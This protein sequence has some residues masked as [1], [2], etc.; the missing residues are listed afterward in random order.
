MG[1]M[2]INPKKYGGLLAKRLPKLIETGEELERFSGMLESLDRLGR[3]L[4]PEEKALESLLLRL[5]QDYDQK[6]E[7]PDA[8]P[9]RV[10]QYL[11]EQ[12][13]LR[14]ADLLPIFGARS[15]ASD[16]VSG[17]REPSKAHI[18]K[19]ADFFHVSPE[20]FL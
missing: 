17:K 13:G 4:T 7:L 12:R 11:M 1:L 6:I 10:I 5:I 19:L 16:V 8:P 15:I 14:K 3:E 20:L 18:R 2:V 9:H